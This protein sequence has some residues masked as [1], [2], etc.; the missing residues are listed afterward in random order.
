MRAY[1][2]ALSLLALALAACGESPTGA[3]FHRSGTERSA[4]LP[5]GAS[6]DGIVGQLTAR[7]RMAARTDA[8][9]LSNPVS[10]A[11]TTGGNLWVADAGNNRVLGFAAAA[12]VADGI[13]ADLVLNQADFHTTDFRNI[14]T[15]PI[16]QQVTPTFIAVDPE[17]RL[18]V[19]TSSN[20]VLVYD[21]PFT[22]DGVA[23]Y[24]LAGVPAD[25]RTVRPLSNGTDRIA[26]VGSTSIVFYL[27]GSADPLRTASV[28]S[29]AT[30]GDFRD[31]AEVTGALLVACGDG[32]VRAHK[33]DADSGFVIAPAEGYSAYSAT[34]SD[35]RIAVQSGKLFVVEP[36]R[37]RIVRFDAPASWLSTLFLQVFPGTPTVVPT[38]AGDAAH[39]AVF[40]QA[41]A[42]AFAANRG[43]AYAVGSSRCGANGFYGPAD[44]A[45]SQNSL[46]VADNSNHRALRFDSAT[47]A[48]GADTVIADAVLGQASFVGRYPNRLE[49]GSLASPRGVAL[50]DVGTSVAA[51]VVD[52]TTHRVLG[53]DNVLALSHGDDPDF[54]LGQLMAGDPPPYLVNGNSVTPVAGG[55]SSPTRVAVS[56]SGDAVFVA[57][58]GN[59]RVLSYESIDVGTYTATRAYGATG[60]TSSGTAFTAGPTALA[61]SST[62]LFVADGHRVLAFALATSGDVPNPIEWTGSYSTWVF[63]QPTS[64]TNTC[65]YGGVGPDTLCTV[66]G[67]AV[68]A[69]NSRLWIADGQNN[70]VLWF[71]DPVDSLTFTAAEGTTADGVVGQPDFV[72][73]SAWGG[74]GASGYQYGFS[75]TGVTGNWVSDIALDDDGTLWASDAGANRVLGF[76]DPTTPQGPYSMP[77]ATTVLG[78]PGFNTFGA[79]SDMTISA[80][81]MSGPT[82]VAVN[83]AG[84]VVLVSDAGNFRVLRYVDNLPPRV[85]GGG[86]F[87]VELGASRTVQLNVSDPEGTAVTLALID[88]VAN[89]SLTGTSVTY[90]ATAQGLRVGD[91]IR[92]PILATDA[93]TPPKSTTVS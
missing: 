17:D 54:M 79:S 5:V 82:N 29:T 77:I 70:R 88:T 66:T 6:A 24:E 32:V 92:T 59:N 30:C 35:A 37:H 8:G 65:N 51:F 73:S 19:V 9:S 71:D 76:A 16:N 3:A 1:T 46:W 28:P 34:T 10:V 60:I 80:R 74:F 58:T 21:D 41:A 14:P 38:L 31:V 93:G 68:A 89:A 23:D 50:V 2:P 69:D 39:D 12:T 53:Y 63:G 75:Y 36:S 44:M 20:H 91:I 11:L 62:H 26:V 87:D 64:E 86:D 13:G 85:S 67:L 61:V 81:S 7:G 22:H 78:Q 84:N 25:I 83:A 57:D 90:A 4:L 33:T 40:G 47:G 45:F 72:S 55:L 49:L 18:Y 27:R 42:D 48:V 15:T 52:S 43:D 56:P